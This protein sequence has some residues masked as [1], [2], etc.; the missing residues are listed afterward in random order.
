MPEDITVLIV[1]NGGRAHVLADLYQRHKDV[2]RVVVAKGNCLILHDSKKEVIL[3]ERVDLNDPRTIL[4]VA[5]TYKP[6]L[7]DVAQDN[8]IACGTVNLLQKNRFHVFGPTKKAARLEWDKAWARE[9]MKGCGVP[10]PDY[11]FFSKPQDAADH[12]RKIYQKNRSSLIFVKASGLCAGKGVEK[13]E[14]IQEVLIAIGKMRMHGNAASTILIEEGLQGEEFSLYALNDGEHMVTFSL[15]QDYKQLQDGGQGKNTGGMGAV[16]PLPMTKEFVQKV[17]EPLVKRQIHGMKMKGVPY[18]G[19]LYVG[20]ILTENGPFVIEDNARWGDPEAQVILPGI[21]NYADLV[22]ASLDRRLKE[23]QPIEDGLSRVCV[24]GVAKGY[25]G[26]IS[27]IIG[28]RVYGLEDVMKMGNVNVYGAG[29][30]KEG[31]NFYVAGGRVFHIVGSGARIDEARQ[32]AYEAVRRVSIEGDNL[33]Y[34]VDIGANLSRWSEIATGYLQ[35]N[36][37]ASRASVALQH[38]RQKARA[39]G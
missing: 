16:A 8:A 3:E 25:P 35:S 1:D 7:V 18:T 29:I 36:Q 22:M 12:A 19:I 31:G 27:S 20:G 28:K 5:I 2:K 13:A 4:K 34:R 24:V 11:T 33:H 32:A 26:D 17:E 39:Q 14:N 10:I 30:K 38:R 9:F 15:A 23:I 6:D 21:G 37:K